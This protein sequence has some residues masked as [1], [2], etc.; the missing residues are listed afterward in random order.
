MTEFAIVTVI[1]DSAAEIEGLLASI[2]RFLDPRPQVV[3]VDS[4]SR[5]DGAEVARRHGAEV[6]VLEDNRGFG[7]ASNAGL[8]QVAAPVTALVN[9]DVELLDAGLLRLVAEA[10]TRNAL[11]VPRLLNAD[12]SVQDSAHP[13]PGTLEALIPA[14]VPRPLLPRPLRRRY[15]P[16]RSTRPRAVG[17]AIAACVVARTELLRRAGPFDA[18]AFLFYEDLELCLRAADLGAPTLLRPSV[19]VRHLGGTSVARALGDA[20][21]EL[22]A[23]RR[24]EVVSG[25]G[26]RALALDDLAQAVTYGTRAVARTV[27]RRDPSYD[28]AQLRALGRAVR[29]GGSH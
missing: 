18:G 29:H 15:E 24:R 28:R 2:E 21:L 23:R 4:G 26:K 7:A 3:V 6:I 20:A 11:L 13:L 10:E 12:G 27:L 25:I 9:P 1:H 17:W 8:E 14:A 5:D 19:A 16:W 22:A